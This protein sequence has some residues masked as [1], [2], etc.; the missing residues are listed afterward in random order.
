MSLP[1]LFVVF[2]VSRFSGENVERSVSAVRV[3]FW[4]VVGESSRSVDPDASRESR[5]AAGG[6]GGGVVVVD[7]PLCNP[8]SGG[9]K[10]QERRNTRGGV[11]S[12]EPVRK[13]RFE[14]SRQE[15]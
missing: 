10:A 12:E 14:V 3:K 4:E 7:S 8:S 5:R 11:R 15:L 13:S 9:T 1:F 2:R 6:G